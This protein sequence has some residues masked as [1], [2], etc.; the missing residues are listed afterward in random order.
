M[1]LSILTLSVL[2]ER[3]AVC[4]LDSDDRIPEWALTGQ[5]VSITR[6]EDELSLVLPEQ[7]IPDGAKYDSG[8]R[9]LKCEGPLDL[10]L[11]GILASLASPLADADISI[12][13]L[14]TYNTDYLLVKESSLELAITVLSEEG[15][16]ILL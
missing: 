2:P 13:A 1:A 14:A 8:W 11:T 5:F 7:R 6:T 16:R 10:S 12:F 9:C 4:R 3:F 15:H